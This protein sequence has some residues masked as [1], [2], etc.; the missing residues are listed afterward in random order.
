MLYYNKPATR[1]EP[2]FLHPVLVDDIEQPSR[3][4][5]IVS[6]ANA[7]EMIYNVTQSNVISPTSSMPPWGAYHVQLCKNERNLPISEVAYNPIIMASPGDIPT[8]YTTLK[9]SKETI[10]MS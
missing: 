7:V 3:M 10:K 2:A 9:R 6:H 1:P 4:S 5:E 8:I